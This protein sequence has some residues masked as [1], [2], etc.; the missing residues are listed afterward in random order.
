MMHILSSPIY[1]LRNLEVE[2]IY[3]HKCVCFFVLVA[4]IDSI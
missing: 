2:V 3:I 4:E 1:F